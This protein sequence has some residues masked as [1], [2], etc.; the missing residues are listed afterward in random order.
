ME[1]LYFSEDDESISLLR[2]YMDGLVLGVPITSTKI[3]S[4][5]ENLTWFNRES[6]N[7]L[8]SKGNY[9][10]KDKSLSFVLNSKYSTVE[11]FGNIINSEEILL[12][13]HSITTGYKSSSLFKKYHLNCND[14]SP[15]DYPVA[16]ELLAG[17][18]TLERLK[19]IPSEDLILYYFGLYNQEYGNKKGLEILSK[20]QLSKKVHEFITRL[21]MEELSP[22]DDGFITVVNSIP[23][24][25]FSRAE[26]LG[27]GALFA[28][29]QW[30][31]QSSNDTF[32]LNKNTIHRIVVETI[33]RAERT[34]V[35][36]SGNLTFFHKYFSLLEHVLNNL[37][38]NL[39]SQND[40]DLIAL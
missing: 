33:F 12:H 20:I 40:F 31:E 37:V 18:L 35:N 6:Y 17:K 7:P 1:E 3:E 16:S 24:F 26:T 28:I 39:G 29:Q 22:G 19:F 13:I 8:W 15:I 23:Y 11:Y 32:Q 21:R 2:F 10:I 38:D 14:S 34:K 25:L 5:A 4:I 27:Y 30:V 9:E 36:L